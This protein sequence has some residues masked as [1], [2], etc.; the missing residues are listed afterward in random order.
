LTSID[1]PD[2]VWL[3]SRKRVADDRHVPG[4]AVVDVPSEK[5][6]ELGRELCCDL[7]GNFGSGY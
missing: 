7:L 4:H 5:V 1:N 3:A 6:G 2:G